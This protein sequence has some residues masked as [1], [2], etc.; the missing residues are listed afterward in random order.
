MIA[1]RRA[2]VPA[3]FLAWLLS[4][5]WASA[6]H[7]KTIII[8]DSG[9]QSLEPSVSMRWKTATPSRSGSDTMMV[10]TTTIRVRINVMPW[11]HRSGRIYLSLPAQQPGPITASW[12]AQG[13]FASGQVHSG[14]RMLVYSGPI[15][16]PFMEDVLKFQ[17]NVDGTLIR[18]AVPVSFH[19][20]MDED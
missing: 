14:N 10:G 18:R 17:F 2:M 19:F 7:A 20:E 11:L 16:T 13:R 6:A 1:G 12:V 9:T 8:D 15:S 4:I 3:F 5:I